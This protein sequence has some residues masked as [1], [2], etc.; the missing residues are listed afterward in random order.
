M[1][2]IPGM[3]L[4]AAEIKARLEETLS[5]SSSV[6]VLLALAESLRERDLHEEAELVEKAANL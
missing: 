4:S 3:A 6:D 1:P 2:Y 5:L